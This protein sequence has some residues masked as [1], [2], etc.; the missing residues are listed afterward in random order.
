MSP[1]V[2]FECGIEQFDFDWGSIGEPVAEE[3][4]T[5]VH[6]VIIGVLQI[7]DAHSGIFFRKWFDEGGPVMLSL[8]ALFE[9]LDRKEA[10][11]FSSCTLKIRYLC[12]LLNFSSLKIWTQLSSMLDF[13]YNIY[14]I[15]YFKTFIQLNL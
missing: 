15:I 1:E 12:F 5:A 8:S 10:T 4:L 13:I 9:D 6:A 11:T 2:F 7:E 3:Q 14:Q